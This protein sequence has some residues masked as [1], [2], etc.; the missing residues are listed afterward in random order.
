MKVV[1]FDGLSLFRA[2]GSAMRKINMINL[3][4]SVLVSFFIGV[5]S[6][7]ELFAKRFSNQYTEFELPTGWICVL[8]GSEYVCQSETED[9]KKEAIIILAAKKR[10]EQDNLD[11]YLGYL[12]QA[13]TY[14]LP[15][16]RVQVSEAKYAKLVSVNEQQ[17]VEALHLASEVPGFYT[18]YMATVKE[19][20]G[21]AVTFSVAKDLYDTYV[22]VMNSVIASLRVFRQRE[23]AVESGIA[24]G[25]APADSSL[26][27]TAFIP[28]GEKVDIRAERTQERKKSSGQDDMLWLLIV[29]GVVVG[30]IILKKRKK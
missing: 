13:K 17:W 24:T 14:T 30:V 1:S 4:T 29:A 7:T 21:V 18:R 23:N 25:T 2:K 8:E 26:E 5:F 27:D 12:K 6:S 9:R 15:G 16:G 10:S 11:E 20:L 22:P 3:K 28:E 19:D